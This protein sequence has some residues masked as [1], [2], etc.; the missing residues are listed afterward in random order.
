M[1][2]LLYLTL[3]PPDHPKSE[4]SGNLRRGTKLVD[5]FKVQGGYTAG[6]LES[7]PAE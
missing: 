1:S 4:L 6:R 2:M 5:Y 7:Y 3:P